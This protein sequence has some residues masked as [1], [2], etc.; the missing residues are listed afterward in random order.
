MDPELSVVDRVDDVEN[1]VTSEILY[2]PHRRRKSRR[3]DPRRRGGKCE[4]CV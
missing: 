4:I 3:H 2:L 1:N